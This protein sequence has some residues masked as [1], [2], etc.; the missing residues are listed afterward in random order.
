MNTDAGSRD[1]FLLDS[2]VQSTYHLERRVCEAT[3]H[4]NNPVLPL[5][6][7]HEWDATQARPWESPTVI[8]DEDDR[9]FKAWY[10]GSD[11]STER[12]WATGY[13]TSPDGLTWEKPELGLHSYE[14]SSNNNIVVMGY[15]P[16]IKDVAEPDAGRRYKMIKRGPTPREVAQR[17]GARANYSPD[18]IHWTEGPRIRI[19]EWGDRT[20]DCGVLLRDDQDPD[21]SRRYKLVWQAKDTIDRIDKSE[22]RSKILAYGPDIEHFRHAEHNPLISPATGFEYEDHHVML[23]PYGG[24][25]IMAYEYG[26]YVPSGTGNYGRYCADVRLAVSADGERFHR[27][28][29]EQPVIP[30][31]AND[32]WDA[33]LLVISDKPAIKDGTIHLFYGGNGE[34]WTSWPGENT[35]D[36]FPYPSTGSVRA[37]RLGLATLREDGFTCLQTPD[38]EVPGYAITTPIERTAITTTLTLNVGSVRHTRNWVEAEL[39]DAEHDTAIPGFSREDCTDMCTDGWR[40][41]VRWR[42]GSLADL[43]ESRFRIRFWIYGAARL[44]AFG[45]DDV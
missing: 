12:W 25:W 29:A 39:L 32:A 11:V 17:L 37:S 27:I 35:P 33:G 24:A 26:W 16:V 5:G 1:G 40:Q 21:A 13:A 22:G 34:E 7:L 31:G 20:P 44:Y 14:G 19:P 42:G 15:G 4:P 45:F 41:P 23:S 6:D 2:N 8:W 30:R 9:V 18:G 36:A 43:K 28:D 3:K 38:R 10:S